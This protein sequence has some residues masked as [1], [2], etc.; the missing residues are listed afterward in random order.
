MLTDFRPGTL[1]AWIVEARNSR[2]S[3]GSH[4]F[5]GVECFIAGI[6]ASNQY[7][8]ERISSPLDDAAAP[9]SVVPGIL[10]EGCR[11]NKFD[12]I[13][14]DCLVSKC[15]PV[16]SAVAG[17]ALVKFRIRIFRK[18]DACQK[19]CEDERRIVETVQCRGHELVF[20]GLR[21]KLFVHRN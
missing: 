21:R 18:A 12:I 11:E 6:G 7:A 14:L 3:A 19:A 17:S 2:C 20:Q 13:I 15:M 4:N 1:S 16:I 10:L 5:R 9:Q 8:R